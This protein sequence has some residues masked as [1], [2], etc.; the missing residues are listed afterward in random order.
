[1]KVCPE[2]IAYAASTQ[3][4]SCIL[5]INPSDDDGAIHR[6]LACNG[7]LPQTV[8]SPAS[9]S[10]PTKTPSSILI[11]METKIVELTTQLNFIRDEL[12]GFENEL[13]SARRAVED[14]GSQMSKS[15]PSLQSLCV[16]CCT[17]ERNVVFYPC[18]HM[19]CCVDCS[20]RIAPSGHG[21][22]PICRVVLTRKETII[23][24]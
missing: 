22:C 16:T 3:N 21:T 18:R 14:S 10:L 12:A 15:S 2:C 5:L 7:P 13:K 11:P 1:M 8:L 23:M 17:K 4:P 20:E 6:C 9:L 24:A 19:V